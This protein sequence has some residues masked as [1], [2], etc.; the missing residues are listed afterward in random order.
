MVAE[1]HLDGVRTARQR[2]QLMAEAD[3]EYRDIGF[4][5]GLDGS[6]GIIARRRVARAVREEDAVRVHLQNI[7][8]R[9]LCRDDRQAAATVNQHTQDVALGAKIVGHHVERQLAFRF[10]F[11][12]VAFQRPAT[13]RPA[14]GFRRGHFFRQVH[15]VQT[16]EGFRFFQRQRRIKVI[17]CDDTTVLC[18]LLAQQTRQLTGIDIGNRHNVVALQVRREVFGV[19]EVAGN[20]RQVANDQALRMYLRGFFVSRIGADIA[21]MRISKSN[22]LARIGRISEDFLITGH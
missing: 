6:D 13:L 16:R 2:Q 18:A 3:A 7:F 4:Q 10:R 19:A 9:R 8:R 21:D 17:P 22:D 12:Q 15:T 1:L 20:Q 5:E 11:R 14:V